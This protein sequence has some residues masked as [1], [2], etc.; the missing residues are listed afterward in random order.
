[1]KTIKSK[2]LN[3]YSEIAKDN[4]R[5]F[6]DRKYRKEILGSSLIVNYVRKSDDKTIIKIFNN[7]IKKGVEFYFDDGYYFLTM[8]DGI[9]IIYNEYGR[10]V[11]ITFKDGYEWTGNSFI[12]EQ[13][14]LEEND[15]RVKYQN[16]LESYH[17]N[18]DTKDIYF[19]CIELLN[20]VEETVCISDISEMI[21]NLNYLKDSLEYFL[22]SNNDE[23][24]EGK[25][26]ALKNMSNSLNHYSNQEKDVSAALIKLNEYRNWLKSLE[27]RFGNSS[28]YDSQILKNI[29]EM[30]AH[31]D[32][33][34]KMVNPDQNDWNLLDYYH[35]EIIRLINENSR[36][37]QEMVN[38]KQNQE[39]VSDTKKKK[40]FEKIT[41]GEKAD[42]L[43]IKTLREY[44]A[45]DFKYDADKIC[46]T[47]A[48]KMLKK[49][50]KKQKSYE[51]LI[52][53]DE[54]HEINDISYKIY[55]NVKKSKEYLEQT[56]IDNERNNKEVFSDYLRNNYDRS[57]YLERQKCLKKSA[58]KIGRLKNILAK[59]SNESFDKI[60][61]NYL[62]VKRRMTFMGT[63]IIAGVL[64]MTS[65]GGVAYNNYQ[66][67]LKHNSLIYENDDLA[68][69]GDED[70]LDV[71]LK[72]KIV[73]PEAYLEG[74]GANSKE[75]AENYI[76]PEKILVG[77]GADLSFLDETETEKLTETESET[78]TETEK[79]TETES[80]TET[81]TEK[82]TET[83]SETETETEKLTETESETETETEKLTETESETETEKLT[84]TESETET[85][86]EELT[87]TESET[88]EET[89]SIEVETEISTEKIL[90]HFGLEEVTVVPDENFQIESIEVVPNDTQEIQ[91]EVESKTTELKI[92]ES[93]EKLSEIKDEKDLLNTYK[94]ELQNLESLLPKSDIELSNVRS[95]GDVVNITENANLQNDEYSLILHSEGHESIHKDNLPRVICSVIM[96]DGKSGITV[97]TMEEVESLV[98]QG[99]YVV[100]Y[101]VLNPY[102]KDASNLEGFFESEDVVG[103]VRK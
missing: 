73:G 55:N 50:R 2:I 91:T 47:D 63:G 36:K 9:M 72:E 87:E 42:Y 78:E 82:L 11:S 41:I 53:K 79:L 89:E 54:N 29:N 24:F 32:K 95:I 38:K 58:S 49:L 61:Q 43:T 100:G 13:A 62:K 22:H 39:E 30:K 80:E 93:V 77:I 27:N 33:I 26:S 52:K 4:S 57:I 85:E 56:D 45:E 19:K 44:T 46:V 81:E 10:A 3:L 84:E 1:M 75:T 102:S 28:N 86:T 70:N 71:G 51:K 68:I 97:K 23:Y 37:E 98:E 67:N 17:T 6:A 8:L 59:M 16:F 48:K 103:L 12:S 31:I 83:E 40:L 101:G 15:L 74:Y 76:G 5:N 20:L 94:A 66:N 88:I 21:N 92:D 99:Y 25:L 65:V 34:E 69:Y 96:S 90:E 35:N 64:A 60:H 18:E 14:V 7:K